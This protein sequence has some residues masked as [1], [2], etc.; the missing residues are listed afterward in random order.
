[1]DDS[2]SKL[3][4]NRK[5]IIIPE[6]IDHD[7][8]SLIVEAAVLYPDDEIDLYC[9]GDGGYSNDAFAMVDVIRKHGRFVG[10]LVGAAASSHG[11]VWA[12]CAI[13]YVYPFGKLGV[14]RVVKNMLPDNL[15]SDHLSQMA[16]SNH[17]VDQAMALI[18]ESSSNLDYSK[19]RKIID[20]Y[21]M[22]VKWFRSDDLI[23]MCMALPIA[24][25]RR[26]T[27]KLTHWD[28]NIHN[29][30]MTDILL[31]GDGK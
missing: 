6:N 20:E 1:M 5:T 17:Q 7:S 31:N 28:E 23:Q 21:S 12:S 16:E 22:C 27:D 14:H 10:H 25:C 30:C 26:K 13:R 24:D 29:Q 19:W 4:E 2:Q 9:R 3:L 18:F 11:V 8:Y 15:T